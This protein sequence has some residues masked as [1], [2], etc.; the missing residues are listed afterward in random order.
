MRLG[1][2][3]NGTAHQRL[4]SNVLMK[5]KEMK[6]GTKEGKKNRNEGDSVILCEGVV[7]IEMDVRNYLS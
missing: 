2:D 1:C 4:E 3:G 5:A 7:M 6:V